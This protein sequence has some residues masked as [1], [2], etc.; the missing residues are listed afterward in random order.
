MTLQTYPACKLVYEVTIGRPLSVPLTMT[1]GVNS[2]PQHG[3]KGQNG[4][5]LDLEGRSE[6]RSERIDDVAQIDVPGAGT[7]AKEHSLLQPHR[8]PFLTH[9][10]N[11]RPRNQR[12]STS[13]RVSAA[14][15]NIC[16]AFWP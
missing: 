15:R 5:P 16:F 1:S 9:M 3:Q 14:A 2:T 10:T 7:E 12:Y 8:E 4:R 13:G 6:R 11:I